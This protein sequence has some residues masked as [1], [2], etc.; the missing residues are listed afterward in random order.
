MSGWEIREATA[1]DARDLAVCHI[2]SWREAYRGLV[3]DHL[4]DAFDIE[5]RARQWARIITEFGTGNPEDLESYTTIVAVD[6][7]R[8]PGQRVL[9]F[10]HA[11]PPR[12]EPRP[13][14]RELFALYVRAARHGTGVAAEV[15]RAILLPDTDTA[16]WVFEENPRAGNFYRKFGFAADGARRIEPLSMA[17]EIRMIARHGTTER[18]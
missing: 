12:D 10:A 17:S 18:R 9:G 14:D 7:T 11:G 8:E 4:L 3:P 5:R 15:M 13:A 16:L 2:E 1:D 6:D